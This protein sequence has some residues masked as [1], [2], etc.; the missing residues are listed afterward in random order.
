MRTQQLIL[1][2]S[3]ETFT[4]ITTGGHTNYTNYCYAL[5]CQLDVSMLPGTRLQTETLRL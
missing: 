2:D 4:E 3:E 1:T 5:I